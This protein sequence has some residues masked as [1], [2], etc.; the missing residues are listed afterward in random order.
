MVSAYTSVGV[1]M[2]RRKQCQLQGFMYILVFGYSG[3]R[4][5]IGKGMGGWLLLLDDLALE[6]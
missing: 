5:W 1:C 6:Q 3:V 2:S 4:P